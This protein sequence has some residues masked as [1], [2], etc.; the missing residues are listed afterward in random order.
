[1]DYGTNRLQIR[2]D[3]RSSI[4]SCCLAHVFDSLFPTIILLFLPVM[5]GSGRVSESDI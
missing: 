3:V 2:G 4:R 5:S 1:M